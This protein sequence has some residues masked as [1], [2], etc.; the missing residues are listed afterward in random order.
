MLPVLIALSVQ[1][2]SQDSRVPDHAAPGTAWRHADWWRGE[3]GHRPPVRP[4]P[5][6]WSGNGHFYEFVRFSS[7]ASNTWYDARTAAS[8]RTF[9]SLPG[10][11]AT[12]TSAQ[13]NDFI[14][15]N[16]NTGVSGEGAWIGGI[17]AKD[18][19]VWRWDCGP[20]AGV[21]FAL[22]RKATAPYHYANWGG[23]EPNHMQFNED[24]LAFNVGRTFAD[25][26]KNG[27]W[28]DAVAKPWRGDPVVGY[29]VEY[30][31]NGIPEPAL[32]GPINPKVEFLASLAV[33]GALPRQLPTATNRAKAGAA[34]TQLPPL[35][36]THSG[37]NLK[38]AWP[39][40]A[41]GYRLQEA[42]GAVP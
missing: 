10:H 17:A 25:I 23:V 24:Y 27:Q 6:H 21:Q 32:H 28:W 34:P 5:R 30:E 26:I 3:G 16:F 4:G 22:G 13:E 2:R 18:D 36:I 19:G 37:E 15:S 20:E 33:K 31:P 29:L 12:I 35:R 39:L 38:L 8:Q 9:A 40:W 41:A 7:T 42:D 14:A 1:T 11:L